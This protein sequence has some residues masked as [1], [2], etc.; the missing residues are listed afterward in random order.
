MSLKR[1]FIPLLRQSCSGQ[2][3][4]HGHRAA[5]SETGKP[6]ATA[7]HNH[8]DRTRTADRWD[9]VLNRGVLAFRIT[10]PSAS[11]S[12]FL[13]GEGE[14]EVM[15]RNCSHLFNI[16]YINTAFCLSDTAGRY[17]HWKVQLVFQHTSCALS[18][19]LLD[20]DRSIQV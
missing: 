2:N 3:T 7:K 10:L 12:Q 18:S 19:V 6:G 5:W 13:C 1:V 15:L 8:H 4:P 16:L 17:F 11:S 9:R 14:L 20:V